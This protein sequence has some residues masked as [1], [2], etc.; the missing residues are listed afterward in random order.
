M[1]LIGGVF[2]P[3]G[4]DSGQAL[5]LIDGCLSQFAHDRKKRWV[6][7]PVALVVLQ[8]EVTPE[9]FD[10]TQPELLDNGLSMAFDGRIDERPELLD[11]L[12]IDSQAKNNITDSRLF[13]AAF[14]KWGGN[15]GRHVI[16]DY[17]CA[18]WNQ[19]NRELTLFTDSMGNRPLFWAALPNGGI[20]FSSHITALTKLEGVSL[21]IDEY[22]VA[23]FLTLTHL[24][25]DRTAYQGVRQLPQA[26]CLKATPHRIHEAR[27]YWYLRDDIKPLNLP[28]V[29]DYY[30]HFLEVFE[31]AIAD[32]LRYRKDVPVATMLSGGLDSS[33]ITVAITRNRQN[34]G[35][36]IIAVSSRLPDENNTPYQDESEFINSLLNRYPD[37]RGIPVYAEGMDFLSEIDRAL[38]IFGQPTRD[39]FY[40]RTFALLEAASGE[41]A[42]LL[43]TGMGGDVFASA[44]LNQAIPQ[45]LHALNIREAFAYLQK[46]SGVTGRHPF[47]MVLAQLLRPRL[48]GLAGRAA[49]FRRYKASQYLD[50]LGIKPQR[51]FSDKVRLNDR[52]E[53]TNTP[54]RIRYHQKLWETEERMCQSGRVLQASSLFSM[55]GLGFDLHVTNPLFDRRVIATSSSI[56]LVIRRPAGNPRA[57]LRESARP[58]LPEEIYRRTTKGPFCP[59]YPLRASR[60]IE[61]LTA[62]NTIPL[63]SAYLESGDHNSRRFK[64]THTQNNGVT[65]ITSRL[66]PFMLEYWLKKN[67]FKKKEFHH[68]HAD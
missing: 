1:G 35:Q 44:G 43:F 65:L 42:K 48:S 13:A 4:G 56:P 60:A 66:L 34:R 22:W 46:E 12:G 21:E 8:R 32:R 64:Q 23:D 7:G 31:R 28:N 38:A 37:I 11:R 62:E 16:G 2:L 19:N 24:D 68:Y 52:I 27:R 3:N 18:V 30:D 45:I 17:A 55:A 9:D 39:G 53:R 36:K 59:D 49:L 14:E 61:R 25:A 67:I 6:Q 57:L 58:L 41:G 10:E 51:D 29:Q 33:S 40:Y 26:H 5:S 63:E 54:P 50:S 15:A 20:A 47:R